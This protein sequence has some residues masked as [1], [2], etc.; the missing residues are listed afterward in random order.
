[1]ILR[2]D[3]NKLIQIP[4]NH[5]LDRFSKLNF[6]NVFKIDVIKK[7]DVH[8]LAVKHFKFI[9]QKN[10]FYKIMIYVVTIFAVVAIDN[11]KKS[12][13][14]ISIFLL[15]IANSFAVVL[16]KIILSNEVIIYNFDN[17]ET[18]RNFQ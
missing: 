12:F 7:N 17:N 1:M 18:M 6:L 15:S 8:N 3:F 11:M 10:Y 9:H 14:E 4:R 5:R 2:N 16:S 13:A